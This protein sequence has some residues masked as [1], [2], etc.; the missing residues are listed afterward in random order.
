MPIIDPN[1]SLIYILWRRT[2]DGTILRAYEEEKRGEEDLD[3]LKENIIS[4]DEY[5]LDTVMLYKHG[6]A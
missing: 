1:Q 3:L 6:V 2:P 5:F 4:G